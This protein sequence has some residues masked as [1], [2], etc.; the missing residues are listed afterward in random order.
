MFSKAV[1]YVLGVISFVPP[2][3]GLL[4]FYLK[5]HGH[6]VIY[7]ATAGCIWIGNILDIVQIPRLVKEANMRYKQRQLKKHADYLDF[8]SQLNDPALNSSV[9][10]YERLSVAEKEDRGPD[11]T[12]S[13]HMVEQAIL[14]SAK[15]NGGFTTPTEV[16][17]ESSISIERAREALDYLVSKGFAEIRINKNG[18]ILYRFPDIIDP[19]NDE[20]FEDLT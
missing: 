11:D 1:A 19:N 9:P 7:T 3:N 12:V 10:D 14:R 18:I 16:A 17:L 20:D 5:K 15:N 4:R 13:E 8:H 2:F 6:G